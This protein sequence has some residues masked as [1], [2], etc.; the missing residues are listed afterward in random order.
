M[1]LE[2]HLFAGLRDKYPEAK[3]GPI[4]I[5]MRDSSTIGDLLEHLGLQDQESLLI[6]KNGLK[7]SSSCILRDDTPI[8]I[9][10]PIGGG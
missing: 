10:P 2:V 9:F 4:F 5:C 7:Q 6:L 3:K 1:Q 8:M